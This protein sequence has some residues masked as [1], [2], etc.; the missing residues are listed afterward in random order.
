MGGFGVSWGGNEKKSGGR[1]IA[2]MEFKNRAAFFQP[3]GSI[4]HEGEG[5]YTK[6]ELFGK[7]RGGGSERRARRL[8]GTPFSRGKEI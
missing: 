8:E 2:A 5:E 7:K 3:R 1:K 6:K 4:G